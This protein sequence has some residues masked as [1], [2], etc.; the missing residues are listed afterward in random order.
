MRPAEAVSVACVTCHSTLKIGPF[1]VSGEHFLEYMT[2]SKV[3][4][5]LFQFIPN[6]GI[7]GGFQLLLGTSKV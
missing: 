1:D 7:F 3:L 6:S 2:A 4:T 5:V